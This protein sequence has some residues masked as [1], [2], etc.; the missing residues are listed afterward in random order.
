LRQDPARGAADERV[1]PRR[2]AHSAR[3]LGSVMPRGDAIGDNVFRKPISPSARL[4]FRYSRPTY[5]FRVSAMTRMPKRFAI[6]VSI[7]C[8]GFSAAYAQRN[9]LGG[10]LDN[11]RRTTLAGRVHPQARAQND[12]GLVEDSFEL[13][14][15]T[16][17]LKPSTDQQTA[18][19]QLLQELQDPSS[20]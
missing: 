5:S 1:G 3:I 9:R 18:L 6:I 7:A 20:P 4:W 11:S 2:R 14:G 15:M 19:R 10:A 12:N 16:L 8:F 17:V 13:P